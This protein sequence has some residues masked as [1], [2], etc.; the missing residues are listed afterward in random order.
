MGG[1]ACLEQTFHGDNYPRNCQPYFQSNFWVWLLMC[2]ISAVRIC[3]FTSGL[4]KS[5]WPIDL[6]MQLPDPPQSSGCKPI[7]DNLSTICSILMYSCLHL[8][9]TCH[10]S[11]IYYC[12]KKRVLF[13]W[14]RFAQIYEHIYLYTFWR[15]WDIGYKNDQFYISML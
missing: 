1:L 7:W 11:K 10:P 9:N 4:P 5:W 2:S 6:N 3:W 12:C 13:D 8:V 15:H 14:K